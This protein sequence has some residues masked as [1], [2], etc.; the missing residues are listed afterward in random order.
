M[1]ER[2]GPRFWFEGRSYEARPGATLLDRL[3]RDGLPTL[4]RSPRYHRARAPFCGVGQCTGCLV[5]VNGRPNVRACRH[6]PA[7]DDRVVTENAWPSRRFDLL[8]ALD[9]VFGRGVDTLHGFRRPAFLTPLYHRVVR[10]LAGYGQPPTEESGRRLVTAPEIRDVGVAI[11][12][13]GRSGRAVAAGLAAAGVRPLV[14]ERGLA[15]AAVPGAD[16]LAATTVTFLPPRGST[17]DAP[18][19]L[20]GFTEPA[21]GVLVRAQRVV[22]ATGSYDASLVFGSNDR[23]GVLTADGA[24]ALSRGAGRPLFERAVVFGATERAA[25]VVELLGDRV[26]AIVAPGEIPPR[27]V[28]AASASGIRLYPRSLLVAAEGRARVRAVVVRPRGGPRATRLRCDAVV[29]AHRRVPNGQLLFQ[30]GARMG[31]RA[32][33]GAYYPVVGE[34]GSTSVVGVGAVGSVS[35]ALGPSSVGSAERLA[36]ALTGGTLPVSPLERVRPDGPTE[37]EGY[38]RE[39]LR[40]PREGR[41]IA[42]PCE[43]VLL[44]EVEAATAGGYRGIEV[45]KRYSG[46]G[47]GLCQGRYCLPDALVLLSIAEGR[48]PPEVGYI[49][50]RPPVHP[51]PIAALAAL[52]PA[53]A[54]AEAP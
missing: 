19:E 20:L 22:V 25:A 9:L 51:T 50:Q 33:T 47:T 24:I 1:P 7:G 46:L 54:A 8:A 43:D 26:S 38:Y 44:E 52:R 15:P 29:L 35:G 49:R 48:S 13:A 45:V 21:R 53:T 41:W 27:L 30:V 10:R 23:P 11:V 17:P 31:W 39:L 36:S 3:V 16:L 14:L 2:S 12:G 37:L 40:G 4:Q 6:V 18:F 32:G 34:D 5:R 42:C 28:H